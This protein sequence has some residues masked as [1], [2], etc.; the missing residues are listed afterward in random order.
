MNL[1]D[2]LDSILVQGLEL[3]GVI[4]GIYILT[5]YIFSCLLMQL[6]KSIM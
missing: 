4:F 5:M 1:S 6:F 2:S 3:P